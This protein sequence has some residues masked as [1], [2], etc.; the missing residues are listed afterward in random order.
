MWW[1]VTIVAVV[2]VLAFFE[3]PSRNKPL[4]PGLQDHWGLHSAAHNESR[5][6][7]GGHDTDEHG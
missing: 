4:A 7:T 6:M 1:V 3:W 5:P 2:T